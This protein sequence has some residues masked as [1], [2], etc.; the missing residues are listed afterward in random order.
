MA[1]EHGHTV[2]RIPP[3]HCQY[4]AVE[5]IWAQV[6]GHAAR[7]NTSPPFTATKMLDLLIKV[8]ESVTPENCASVV[9]KT[10]NLIM[11]DWDRDVAFDNITIRELVINVTK[12]SSDDDSS[13]DGEESDDV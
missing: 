2:V 5:L 8:C 10:K 7:N 11:S 3:N 12:N 9:E 6:K 1:A 13:S 4:N